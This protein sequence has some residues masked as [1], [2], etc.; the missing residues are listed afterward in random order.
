[1]RN[2]NI[3]IIYPDVS[4]SNVTLSARLGVGPIE[5]KYN[6]MAQVSLLEGSGISNGLMVANFRCMLFF[7]IPLHSL[8][9][10]SL[11]GLADQL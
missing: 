7:L 4:G 10:K 5:P 9:A 11:R 3:F 6:S 1:M 2:S 8:G